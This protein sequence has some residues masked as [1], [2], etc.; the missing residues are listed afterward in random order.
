MLLFYND[1]VI[2]PDYMTVKCNKD[3][4]T[5]I[6]GRLETSTSLTYDN[7]MDC[8]ASVSVETGY[9]IIMVYG[10]FELEDKVL[11]VCT[12][13][14]NVHDGSSTSEV[15]INTEPLCGTQPELKN[16]TSS[17]NSVTFHFVSDSNGVFRGF[18]IVYSAY[19]LPPCDSTE[20][21][22]SNG[23]CIHADLRCDDIQHCGDKSDE[24]G[25]TDDAESDAPGGVNTGLVAGVWIFAPRAQGG[26]AGALSTFSQERKKDLEEDASFH[27][28][29][30]V[31]S[32]DE[33]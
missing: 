1:Y 30:P 26:H 9:N 23:M 8:Y 29:A 2:V 14:F 17:G 28:P 24:I 33:D 25:C 7:D 11:G 32:E 31:M 4:G 20:F 21:E 18:E 16:M 5:R 13:I 22:C 12:D 15:V 27:R 10:R 19:R 6:S 3:L